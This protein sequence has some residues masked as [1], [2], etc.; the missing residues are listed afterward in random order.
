MTSFPGVVPNIKGRVLADTSG[1][2]TL[3]EKGLYV[4]GWLKRGP[5]GII[6]TNLY[7]AEETVSCS[8]IP[9]RFHYLEALLESLS[10]CT[11]GGKYIRRCSSRRDSIRIYLAKAWPTGTPSV[12]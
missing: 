3:L 8:C 7:C 11:I 1:D 6:A 12:A 9:V 4:C 2:P 5:T 10:C